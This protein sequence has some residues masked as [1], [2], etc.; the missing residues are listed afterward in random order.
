MQRARIF[1]PK[2]EKTATGAIFVRMC[3]ICLYMKRHDLGQYPTELL[4]TSLVCKVGLYYSSASINQ[5]FNTKNSL[6]HLL[7]RK[8]YSE[9]WSFYLNQYFSQ[10]YS[11]E[12][13]R[14]N[15]KLTREN[16]NLDSEI[17]HLRPE[18]KK[19]HQKAAQTT[20][21]L[22]SSESKNEPNTT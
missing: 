21:K 16:L 4:M 20:A 15:V 10:T 14:R 13:V 19:R 11:H 5:L 6:L 1:G 9:M 18:Y 17:K 7:S 3:D 22:V 8:S 12:I 2:N